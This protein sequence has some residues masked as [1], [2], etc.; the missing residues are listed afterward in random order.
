MLP[1]SGRGLSSRNERPPAGKVRSMR[2]GGA[3]LALAGLLAVA[4]AQSAGAQGVRS[5]KSPAETLNAAAERGRALQEALHRYSWY[6][7]LTIET[8]SDA[9]TITGKYYRLSQVSHDRA[10]Q[11]QERLIEN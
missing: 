7:E 1:I 9:D 8:V 4:G 3:L 6:S 2:V 11:R 5:E 10:G